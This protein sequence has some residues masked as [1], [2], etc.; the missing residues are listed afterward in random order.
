M[1]TGSLQ[2]SLIGSSVVLPADTFIG[3]G[4]GKRLTVAN[5]QITATGLV[6][7]GGLEFAP[8]TAAFTGATAY[9]FDGPVCPESIGLT[10][11]GS[12]LLPWS[13]LYLYGGTAITGSTDTLAFTGG[14]ILAT[15]VKPAALA[16]T[17]GT[18]ATAGLT[19]TGGAGGNTTITSTGVGGAGGALAMTAGAGGTAAVAAT[20]GTGGDGGAITFTTGAGAASAVTG[21]GAGIGGAGSLLTLQAGVGGAVTTSS[22]TNTGGG[23]G[24]VA[25]IGGVGGAAAGGTD[26]GGVGGAITLTAGNGGNS[27]VGGKGG[28]ITLTAGTA[29][30]GGAAAGGIIRM[31]SRSVKLGTLTTLTSAGGYTMAMAQ[32]FGFTQESGATGGIAATTPTGTEI[33][34]ALP[35][36]AVGDSWEFTIANPGNQT[37]TL[38]AGAG[39]ITLLGTVTVA[40]LNVKTFYCYITGANAVSI[41]S[42]GTSVY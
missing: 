6:F 29:G 27:D 33:C 42:K 9:T 11:L 35:G 41:Y 32:M 22:G 18:A 16:T 26:T 2:V 10:D 15:G 30:T 31:A 28:G 12:A 13:V 37:V 38:T 25:I 36:Y 40:T 4:T 14:N 23:G 8:A 34:A 19:I 20:S 1:D 39:G 17:P 3:F 21:A 5:G 7:S 24:G